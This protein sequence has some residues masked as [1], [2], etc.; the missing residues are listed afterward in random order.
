MKTLVQCDFD[1]T[2]TDEDASFFLLDAYAGGD[3]R[4]L[5]QDYKDHRITVGE[6]NTRAFAMVTA[7]RETMLRTV[8]DNIRIRPGFQELL[9]CCGRKGFRFVIVSNGLEF[10]IRATL[11]DI[12]LEDI[13]LHAAMAWF[14]PEGM[15]VRYLGPDGKPLGD[16][17]KLEYMKLFLSQGYRVI[18]AGNGDSDIYAAKYAHKVFATGELLKYFRAHGLRC[19]PFNE[20]TDIVAGLERL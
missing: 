11:E 16:G 13:E 7:D 12:G 9:D 15:K 19:Q 2:I 8:K 10:Y 6:F 5:L 4:G 3:W 17:L 18:Y 20:L 1:G 14:R